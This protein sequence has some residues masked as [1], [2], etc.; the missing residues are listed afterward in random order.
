VS[1]SEV[2]RLES[3]SAAWNGLPVVHEVTF[4]LERGEL[5]SLLGPNG[6]GKTTLLRVIAGLEEP[7]HGRVLLDGRDLGNVPAH[8]RGIG[9]LAQEPA[10]FPRRSAFENIAYGLRLRRL[11]EGEIARKVSELAEFLGIESLLSRPPEELS[12]GQRQRVALARA[13]APDPTVLL[14]DEPFENLDP[15]IRIELRAELR[16]LLRLRGISAIHV[17]HD[18][19]E[20]L[21][22]GD[23]AALIRDGHFLQVG[24]PRDVFLSPSSEGAA[25][26]LGYNILT[27]PDSHFAVHPSDIVPVSRGSGSVDA[28]VTGIGPSGA[29]WILHARIAGG[30]SAEVRGPGAPPALRAGEVTGLR[31]SRTVELV[32]NRDVSGP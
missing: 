24:S 20:G 10:L 26:L 7:T 5:L 22:L 32:E 9:L 13:I 21:F 31:F 18:L 29:G 23:R 17:T 3:V 6:S 30:G 14:L 25:R 1:P 2:L 15:E 12:G 4:N 19:E 16:P 28:T 27:G 11:A 8:R